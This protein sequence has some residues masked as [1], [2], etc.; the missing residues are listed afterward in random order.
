LSHPPQIPRTP[1]NPKCPAPDNDDL[2][3]IPLSLCGTTIAAEKEMYVAASTSPEL[4]S[5]WLPQ[6]WRLS[7]DGGIQ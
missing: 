7:S 3:I 1:T 2:G 4:V 6:C 5:P